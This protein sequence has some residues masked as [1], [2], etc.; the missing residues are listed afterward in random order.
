MGAPLPVLGGLELKNK[1]VVARF[2]F[3]VPLEDGR[4]ADASRIDAAL[5]TIRAVLDAGA[6]RLVMMSHLGRPGGRPVPGLSLEPVAALLAERLGRDVVLAPSCLG[7]GLKSLL[8]LPASKLVLLENLRF[9]GEETDGDHGFAKALSRHGDVYVNDAFGTSHRKHASTYGINAFF[10]EGERAAGLLLERETGA[11][12]RLVRGAR[13]PFAAVVGGAKVADKIG[14]VEALL[15][16]VDALLVGGAMAYPFLKARGRG[17]GASLCGDAD[18]ELARGVLSSKE[19]AARVRLPLDHVA[20]PADDPDAPPRTTPGADVEEGMAGMD[21]GP[22]TLADFERALGGAG[23][24]LWNGPMGLFEKEPF[25][26]GT[27]A[28]AG[29]LARLD[30]FTVVGGGDSV[31]AVNRSGLADKMGHV[32]TGGGAS[33]EFIEK[34]SLP[35]VEALKFGAPVPGGA[36]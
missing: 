8:G 31:S 29:V 9:H 30:A 22:R 34:G 33:L 24:V 3:N 4:V 5:P 28:M 2:D 23:T 21:V 20:V 18:V 35:G 7:P 11:L 17:V 10:K 15:G 6:R 16:R 32:S 12:G 14:V 26:A 13:R 27:L 25:A 1:A 19:R 36:E